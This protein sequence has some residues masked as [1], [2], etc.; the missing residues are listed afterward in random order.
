MFLRSVGLALAT[1]A[2]SAA[3]FSIAVAQN[4]P[5]T[6]RLRPGQA[7]IRPAAVAGIAKATTSFNCT[8][9]NGS[10]TTYTLSVEGGGCLTQG[11]SGTVGPPNAGA[12]RN[13][14]SGDAVS[15]N[16]G[17]G[18]GASTGTGSCTQTTTPPR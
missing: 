10:V 16:C 11:T 1:L 7:P 3:A 5:P 18:C 12:C 8:N 13:Q 15:A 2:A 17:T 9:R 4:A 6:A 14:G